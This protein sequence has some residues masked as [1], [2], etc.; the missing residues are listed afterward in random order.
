MLKSEEICC[1]R[2]IKK[3]YPGAC[4]RSAAREKPYLI[5]RK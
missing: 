5:P 1:H 3:G 2:K 4:G